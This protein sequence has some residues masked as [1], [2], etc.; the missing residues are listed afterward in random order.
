MTP[1]LLFCA[2]HPK[3]WGMLLSPH[4]EVLTSSKC[5]QS[6]KKKNQKYN[7]TGSDENRHEVI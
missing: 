6:I 3:F 5:Y 7:L 4:S 2:K 1:E